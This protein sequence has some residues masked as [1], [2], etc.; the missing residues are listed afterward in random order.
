MEHTWH[1]PA[2]TLPLHGLCIEN[3]FFAS[4]NHYTFT[5]INDGEHT[6]IDVFACSQQLHCGVHNCRTTSGGVESDHSA[7]RLDLMMMLLKHRASTALT[8][9][10]TDWQKIATHNPT[11]TQYNNIL[12]AATDSVAMSYKDFNNAIITAGA[13]TA[14]LFQSTHTN[15][16]QFLLDNLAPI[17]AE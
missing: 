1:Q 2:H 8:Q 4:P 16:F 9:G 13:D 12:L 11:R 14:L 10:T 15:W 7:V 17:I 3:T 5:N 6:M